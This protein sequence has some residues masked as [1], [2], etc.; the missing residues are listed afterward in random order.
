ML[1]Q[2]G[3]IGHEPK[4]ND[5]TMLLKQLHK[6]I[7]FLKSKTLFFFFQIFLYHHIKPPF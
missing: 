3:V 6:I 2:I 7:Q 5:S 1:K 4:K